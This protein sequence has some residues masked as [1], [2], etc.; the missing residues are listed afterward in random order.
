MTRDTLSNKPR[1][2][3]IMCNCKSCR[4]KSA[5]QSFRAGYAAAEEKD[6]REAAEAAFIAGFDAAPDNDQAGIPN[7]LAQ[8]DGIF[9]EMARK[10]GTPIVISA[11]TTAEEVIAQLPDIV[12][13]D[14]KA[15]IAA[16]VLA[17]RDELMS[18][19]AAGGGNQPKAPEGEGPKRKKMEH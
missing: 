3:K 18:S 13:D 17:S 1:R 4:K 5:L 14:I 6:S 9:G 7:F 2:R 15:Q 11:S 19:A 8:L 10:E 16:N 12:P